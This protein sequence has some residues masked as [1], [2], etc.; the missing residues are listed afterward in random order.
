MQLQE[1]NTENVVNNMDIKHHNYNERT[2]QNV[3][4]EVDK[5]EIVENTNEEIVVM[6]KRKWLGM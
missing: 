1:P 4:E 2:V 5:E 3:T 6:L